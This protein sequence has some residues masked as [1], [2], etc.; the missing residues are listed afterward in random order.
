MIEKLL[1]AIPNGKH[2]AIFLDR[3]IVTAQFHRSIVCLF[4]VFVFFF[5]FCSLALAAGTRK[6]LLF[7]SESK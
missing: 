6:V 3:I 2:F 4:L 1:M 5:S 7:S